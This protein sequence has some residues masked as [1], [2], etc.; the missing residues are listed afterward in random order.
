MS[1]NFLLFVVL[2][3]S[4]FA[5][6]EQK[7][8][9]KAPDSLTVGTVFT[10]EISLP[11]ADPASSIQSEPQ[12]G[13]PLFDTLQDL[14]L[15]DVRVVEGDAGIKLS[16]QFIFTSGGL[17]TLPS[18]EF[19][20][21]DQ[22]GKAKVLKSDSYPFVV[23]SLLDTTH[24]DIA[25]IR[26]PKSMYLGALEY[27]SIVIGLGILWGVIFVLFHLLKGKHKLAQEQKVVDNRPA[28]QVGLQSLRKAEKSLQKGNLLEYFFRLSFAL[29]FFLERSFHVSATQMTTDEL[30]EVIKLESMSQ[31]NKL[32][33]IFA[34]ADLVKFAKYAGDNVLAED[35]YQWAKQLFLQAKKEAEIV[36]QQKSLAKSEK[37]EEQ[38]V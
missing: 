11:D 10:A 14:S 16:H 33:E 34:Y 32:F 19:A 23:H 15:L 38:D 27:L 25:D 1:R 2:L 4:S 31:H 6:A 24:K 20:Y 12:I 35:Y 5:W 29:R 18:L 22:K 28:W 30:K 8:V 3:L 7:W 9:I 37:M 36:A 26:P 13:M 17:V 21:Q